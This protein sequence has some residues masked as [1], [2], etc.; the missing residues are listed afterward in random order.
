[1]TTKKNTLTHFLLKICKENS[2]PFKR[3]RTWSY[4]F[5]LTSYT[6]AK[7]KMTVNI[8]KLYTKSSTVKTEFIKIKKENLTLSLQIYLLKRLFWNTAKKCWVRLYVARY[9]NGMWIHSTLFISNHYKAP[10]DMEN[11][12]S[13]SRALQDCRNI[14]LLVSAGI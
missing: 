3:K 2:M 1:M 7:R 6:L 10:S 11:N 13:S 12:F 5:L 8:M 14:L 9:V 4:N